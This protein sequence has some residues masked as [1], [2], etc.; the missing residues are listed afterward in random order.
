MKPTPVKRL[1][2]NLILQSTR[3]LFCKHVKLCC[4]T[5]LLWATPAWVFAQAANNTCATATALTVSGDCNTTSGDFYLANTTIN[6]T[7]S[8]SGGNRA[9]V[10]YTVTVPAN[11]TFITVKVAITSSPASLTTSNTSVE[12]FNTS[13]CT[14]NNTSLG[15]GTI[16]SPRVFGNLIPGNTYALRVYTT[17]TPNTGSTAWRFNICVTSNDQCTNATTLTP[18]VG[19]T[20]AN[21]FGASASPAVPAGCS[22]GNPDDDVWY[23]FTAVGSYATVTL[24]SIGS[25]I[26]GSGARM[27]LFSGT[28]GALSPVACGTGI[29]NVPSGLTA[30]NTYYVRVYTAGTGQTGFTQA[31]SGFQISV[32][33]SAPVVVSSGRM[34]EMYHQTILSADNVID[35]PWEVTYG[36]DDKLWV[37]ESKGYRLFRID[38]VTGNRDTLLDIS[39]GSTFLPL[40]DQSFN[41]TFNI[42]VN[43]PQGGFAGLAIHPLFMAPSGAQNYVYL[44][45]VHTY[46]GTTA[47]AITYV[48]RVVRF[49][50]NTSTGKL[51]S[52]VSIC[53]TLPG[54]NDHNSQRMIIV[55]V[56]GTYYL[57][58]ASGDMGAGQFSNRNRP[59][60]A[61]NINS[62]EGKILR[63]NLVP[64]A[65]AGTYDKWIPNDNPYNATLGKQSAIWSTGIRNNQGFAYDSV[66]NIL[67]GS[68]H[69]PYSDDEL[70]I[71]ESGKNYG[72]PIVIGYAS[73]N[74]YN[75]ITAGFPNGT[76]TC[77]TIG[78]ETTNASTIGASY[79]DPLFSAYAPSPSAATT[80]WTTNPPNGTWPSEGWSGL[81]LYTKTL[82]PGWKNS[83]VA[84]SLKWGRL[85]KIRLNSNG[86]STALSGN[87][88]TVSYFGSTNRF[89]D[90]ALHSNGLDMFVIMDRSAT[91]SGPSA[92]N[93]VVPACPGCLQKYSFLGYADVGGKSSIDSSIDVNAGTPNAV[94]AATTININSNNNTFWVPITGP[95]GDIIAEIYANGENLGTVTTSYYINSGTIRNKGNARYLDRNITITPQNQPTGTVKVRFYITKAEF[96]ALDAHPFS[97]V[98]TISDVKIHKN[99]DPCQATIGST[100]TLINPTFAEARSNLGTVTSY[101]LQADISSF[102]SFYFGAANITLPLS[103][104]NFTGKYSN[105]NGL[106]NWETQREINTAYF[107]VER[108]V[109]NGQ[110]DSVG[111]IQAKGN[112]TN[113]KSGYTFTDSDIRSLGIPNLF[114]R[115]KMVDHNGVYSYSGVVL[116]S[117][118][119]QGTGISI[120]PN[121]AQKQTTVTLSVSAD[122]TVNWQLIDNQGRVLQ[123]HSTT[124]R[125]G[126]NRIAVDLRNLAA[127]SY[128]IRFTGTGVN[129]VETV[130]KQ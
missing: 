99:N 34:K 105:G 110:F 20:T 72:H 26:T 82:V 130:Q 42:S 50:Y 46:V 120:W 9:D 23:K 76:S 49:N 112:N 17:V 96:D 93:P 16:A 97:Q 22:T 75:G 30:G 45:Y 102:S 24:N 78:S 103:L 39:N 106:L 100:T 41:M 81:D 74:N 124:V 90:L 29:I 10:W 111:T 28:C 18:G 119:G 4:I 109:G 40:A 115:L 129:A 27:Q 98:N 117:V 59:Q 116:I 43:N 8:C 80:L 64:D 25:S 51:E 118:P 38:P 79:K 69:G 84:S 7:A 14:L 48:N 73:D 55:P 114:Y 104:L 54:S 92:A 89:R 44:S 107:V 121:P 62:Y 113:L 21:L 31:N 60:N 87:K 125:K 36:P 12:L 70:N 65:D 37:T 128:F 2:L 63:F 35:N 123:T 3:M 53:D 58:Y 6:P 94:T 91:T 86:T 95:Q 66:L 127:G 61:Q 19:L 77:P 33:P 32:T 67:Y 122:Q 57:F 88:D 126:D 11:S 101:V 15:C 52:P 83:L 5:V 85:V 13:T 108:S 47:S 71:I 56:S 68:S 1:T